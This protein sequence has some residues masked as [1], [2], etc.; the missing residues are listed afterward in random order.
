M[1]YCD[2][3]LEF[4]TYIAQTLGSVHIAPMPGHIGNVIASNMQPPPG[5]IPFG[6]YGGPASLAIDG[7]IPPGFPRFPGPIPPPPA[8]IPFARTW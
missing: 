5:T 4:R 2:L 3:F 1:E 7:P 8:A 6:P